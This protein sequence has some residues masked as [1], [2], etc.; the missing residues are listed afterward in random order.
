MMLV[1]IDLLPDRQGSD[2]YMRSGSPAHDGRGWPATQHPYQDE[3]I[4]GPA[5][6]V[7]G[8]RSDP[9]ETPGGAATRREVPYGPELSWPSGF[10]PLDAE[11]REVLEAGYGTGPYRSTQPDPR[12]ADSRLADPRYG[13]PR[14]DYGAAYQ[15]PAM[16]DYGYG[17]PGY[18]DPSYDGPRGPHGGSARGQGA[19]DRGVPGY[20]VPEDRQPRSGYQQEF[21]APSAYPDSYLGTGT[22]SGEA[23]PG[24]GGGQDIYPTTGAM[25]ALTSTDPFG[26]SGAPG[27][28]VALG[29]FESR[30]PSGFSS[31]VRPADPRLAGLRYD[32]LRYDESSYDEP[33]YD[34]PQYHQP[35]DVSWYE[36]LRRSAPVYPDRPDGRPRSED[37]RAQDRPRAA[38]P[39]WGTSPRRRPDQPSGY[40][41]APARDQGFGPGQPRGSRPQMGAGSAPSGQYQVS[42]GPWTATAPGFRPAAPAA[43][44][45]GPWL[46]S[47]AEVPPASWAGGLSE[48][49]TSRQPAAFSPGPVLE[50]TAFLSA[51][52]AQVGVLTPPDGTRLDD[53]PPLD[54]VGAGAGAGQTAT[55]W[56]RPGHGPDRPEIT[57]SW[58]ARPQADD[59]D[60]FWQDD[61]EDDTYSALFADDDDDFDGRRATSAR[62]ARRGI[63]RRRG[64]SNDHRLWIALGGVVIAA[65]AAITGIIKFEFPAHSGPVHAMTVP[66]KIGTYVETVNLER[67]TDLSQLRQDVIKMSAGEASD[68]K[69]A[70]YESGDSAAGGTTQIVMF[71]GGHLA[72]ADP[73]SSIASFTHS[74]PGAFVVSAGSLG[75]EAACVESKAG[76]SDSVAMCAW[77]DDDSFG[78]IVSPTMSATALGH[79]MLTIRPAVEKVVKK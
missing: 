46:G 67:E 44:G 16:E 40:P 26:S 3:A 24:D 76:T 29:S 50:A 18:S 23:Y 27:P 41:Q 43:A 72:N 70:V 51:P 62:S 12:L 33:S 36:D 4:G 20:Q 63:G 73:A 68:V 17:D 14:R 53:M 32:E 45:P 21:A 69:S 66:A 75:G 35:D 57:S 39:Q 19:S 78:E 55:A 1:I 77:F 28:A 79:E 37:R 42:S 59:V 65:A 9:R 56:V 25:E 38:D 5:H 15:Q 54:A 61:D 60:A 31:P 22:G 52:A 8:P 13:A 7:S 64:G 2:R 6:Y 48:P 30:G 58:P 74:N 49:E 10:R 71:I 34:G 11:T 47:P